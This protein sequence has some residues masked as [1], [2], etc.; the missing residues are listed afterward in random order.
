M[1]TS[2]QGIKYEPEIIVTRHKAELLETFMQYGEMCYSMIVKKGKDL[3]KDYNN[4]SALI[5]LITELVESEDLLETKVGT[6]PYTG[7]NAQFWNLKEKIL[8]PVEEYRVSFQNV[9]KY[10]KDNQMIAISLEQIEKL[11]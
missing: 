6:C 2:K 4:N 7:K 3:N 5:K 8:N 10:M 9:A 1:H 11:L